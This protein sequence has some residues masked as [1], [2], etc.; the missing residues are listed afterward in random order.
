MLFAMTGFAFAGSIAIKTTDGDITYL[1][2]DPLKS[3]VFTNNMLVFNNTVPDK[4]YVSIFL[5]QKLYFDETHS[6][7]SDTN[8]DSNSVLIYP[9]PASEYITVV[10]TQ[11]DPGTIAIYDLTGTLVESYQVSG[12]ENTFYIGTFPA[13]IYFL[14]TENQCVKFIKL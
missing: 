3:I 5:C 9:N 6:A 8:S 7:I 11:N 13:G 1:G 10:K 12:Q 4:H 2:L 14:I